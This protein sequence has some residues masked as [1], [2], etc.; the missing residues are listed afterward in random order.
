MKANRM[1]IFVA[2]VTLSAVFLLPK[3]ITVAQDASSPAPR[4]L[5]AGDDFQPITDEDIQM[6]RKDIRS[7]RKQIIAANMKLTDPKRRNSGRCM[8]ITFQ[9]WSRSTDQRY[10]VRVNQTIPAKWWLSDRCRGRKHRQAVGGYRSVC[11]RVENEIHPDL[12]QGT[13]AQEHRTF[14]PVGPTRSAD[15]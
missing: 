14:L 9:N 13:V 5:T 7:Q 2:I 11:G 10:E 8:S 3:G 6:M 12:P 1:R 4:K 15:D